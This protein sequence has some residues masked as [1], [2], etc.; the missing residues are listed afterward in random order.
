MSYGWTGEIKN[1]NHDYLAVVNTNI[2]GGKTDGA[3]EQ[4]INHEARI[5]ET[6]RIID[7][8]TITRYHTGG[9]DLLLSDIQNINYL[10]IYVPGGSR[11]IS[12]EGFTQPEANLF[13]SPEASFATDTLLAETELD[14]T[15]DSASQTKIY[16]E[17]NK[18]VFANW[19]MTAPGD[20]TV[21]KITYELPYRLEFNDT[22]VVKKMLGLTNQNKLY[23]L[24]YQKQSGSQ[25]TTLTSTLVLPDKLNIIATTNNENTNT[26][27]FNFERDHLLGYIIET[28]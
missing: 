16:Q 24:F 23:S 13:K 12:A 17:L 7:T 10:R 8:L 28:K 25:N 15:M 6:G 21:I 19:T 14:Q 26:Q 2:N 9:G 20:T 18:T 27:T 1:T 4:T 11:L 22:S 5:D 3:I